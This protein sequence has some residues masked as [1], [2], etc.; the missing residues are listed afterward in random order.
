M[1]KPGDILHWKD[2]GGRLLKCKFVKADS[3]YGGKEVWTDLYG[4]TWS[5]PNRFLL[6][7]VRLS[8]KDFDFPVFKGRV[9]RD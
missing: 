6:D 8:E 2:S 4:G 5:T 3:V 7:G 9:I 1:I